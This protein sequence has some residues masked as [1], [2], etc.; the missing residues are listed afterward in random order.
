MFEDWRKVEARSTRFDQG[1]SERHGVHLISVAA[2]SSKAGSQT[3]SSC[4]KVRREHG[5]IATHKNGFDFTE[6]AAPHD[7]QTMKRIVASP[8]SAELGLL[9]SRLEAEGIPC[10]IRN[11]QVAQ[12][13]PT[14]AFAG[15]LCVLDEAD[16]PRAMKLYEGWQQTPT[17]S[18]QPWT[19]L[20][21]GE[22]LEGQFASC[23]KC[24]AGR[25]ANAPDP[26]P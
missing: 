26:N 2:D 17:E 16:Y 18:Q 23:W 22:K 15:E 21:C 7:H 24:G 8:N 25:D 11:E 10:H 19:C 20:R 9:K 6:Q 5:E 4:G 1:K 12:V 3:A 13:I 14:T